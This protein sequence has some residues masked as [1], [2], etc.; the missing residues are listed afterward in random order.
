MPGDEDGGGMSAFVVFSMMGFYPV[1]PGVPVYALTSPVF[2]KITIQLHNGR[3]VEIV[4]RNNSARNKY[5]QSLKLNGHEMSR[6]WLTH[7]DLLAGAKLEMQMGNLPNRSLGSNPAD[8]PPSGI[9]LN[10]TILR[11]EN[12]KAESG[13]PERNPKDV[14]RRR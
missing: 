11:S 8:L 12:P 14:S 6:V 4:C 1:T 7:A 13:K 9:D 3:T 2:D 5:I 10:P